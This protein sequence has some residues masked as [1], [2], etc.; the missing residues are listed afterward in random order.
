MSD[1]SRLA[2]VTVAASLSLVGL[3]TVALRLLSDP[4]SRLSRWVDANVLPQ[5][6]TWK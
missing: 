3:A 2:E 5:G 1:T 6:V 4:K